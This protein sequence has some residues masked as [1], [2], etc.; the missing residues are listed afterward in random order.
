MA[1]DVNNVFVVLG[2]HRSG[3]SALTGCLNLLGMD[4]GEMIMP[5]NPDNIHGFFENIDIYAVHERLFSELGHSWDMVGELPKGWLSSDAA[6]GA[7]IELEQI[8]R[9]QFLGK[10]IWTIKDPRMCRL[11][12][13]WD[14]LF[15]KLEINPN[16]IL[17][18]RDP[19]EVA[20]SLHKRDGMDF[21]KAC[22]LWAVH[23]MEAIQSMV[24]GSH[25]IVTYDQLLSDPIS[26]LKNVS[27]HFKMD[28]LGEDPA[29][30]SKIFQFVQPRLKHN[31]TASAAEEDAFDFRPYTHVYRLLQE[32][33]LS[34]RDAAAGEL[35]PPAKDVT[36]THELEKFS[37]LPVTGIGTT[38]QKDVYFLKDVSI[39]K[40]LLSVIGA[41]ER[42]ERESQAAAKVQELF[43]THSGQAFRFQI[44]FPLDQT[45][46]SVHLEKASRNVY[47]VPGDWKELTFDIPSPRNLR[48]QHVRIDPINQCGTIAIAGIQLQD[49]ASG[50][51][52]WE[53]QDAQ[54]F[55]ELTYNN[56]LIVFSREKPLT[57]FSIGTDPQI[58]LPLLP[59]LPDTPVRLKIWIKVLR[60]LDALRANVQSLSQENQELTANT[61]KLAQSEQAATEQAAR[62]QA[63]EVELAGLREN[64]EAQKAARAAA[65]KLAQERKAQAEQANAAQA[66]KIQEAQTE[67]AALRENAEAQK[68]ARAA[69][70]KLAQDRKIQAEQANVAQAAKIQEAQAEQ[71]ALRKEVEAQK[72]ARAAAEKLAQDRKIQAEQANAAQAAKIQEAQAEQA[73]LRKEVEAQKAARAAVE[74]LAQERR[75]EVEQATNEK[76]A[77][78][79]EVETQKAARAAVE[80]LAQDRRVEVEQAANQLQEVQVE[81]THLQDE[82]ITLREEVE[83]QKA[84]RTAAEKLAQE[85]KTQVEQANAAQAAK[86]QEAQTELAALRKEAEAQKAARAAAEKLAQDRKTEIE[87]AALR[88]QGIQVELTRF[89]DD[90]AALRREVDMHKVLRAAAEKLA[91]DHKAQAEQAA[92]AQIR[93]LQEAQ[94]EIDQLR[95]EITTL[96]KNLKSRYGEVATLTTH[97]QTSE[98][99]KQELVSALENERSAATEAAQKVQAELVT[100]REEIQTQKTARAAAE[101]QAQDRKAEAEQNKQAQAELVKARNEVSKLSGKLD[102]RYREVAVLTTQLQS[103]DNDRS[104]LQQANESTKKIAHDE[105]D[106]LDVIIVGLVSMLKNTIETFKDRHFG[107]AKANEQLQKLIDDVKGLGLVDADWYLKTHQDVREAGMDPV[108][109]YILHG[110]LEN[111]GY[112]PK[113]L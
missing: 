29:V 60:T 73:A 101:K 96:T 18:V 47:L 55:A 61:A 67:L 53:A 22:L 69:V 85:R 102:D 99:E 63:A 19:V 38:K 78:R 68:A 34:T 3:T 70:E 65:E 83:A 56:Q 62:I 109:H 42:T 95:E 11:M 72:A 41:Y 108:R 10:R 21:N 100:L 90:Q 43:H 79:K 44:F 76:A 104:K 35:A 6:H 87:Q 59:Q 58:M 23:N 110:V 64:V 33:Q 8:L 107:K 40:D 74:K 17:M 93:R 46:G 49:A 45:N 9:T 84:A 37:F 88:L 66:A 32:K 48:K 14:E 80:K 50:E 82:L 54:Q 12:P 28:L 77:L 106:R 39:V 4:L 20:F 36:G 27:M 98:N 16:Y 97:L 57:C 94:S 75:V 89:Q 24:Q 1:Y 5:A 52:L 92:A 103:A 71:A 105:L 112:G 25:T 51:I 13:L 91:Q 86:I 113:K 30:Y 7:A 81:L 15:R 31:R 26:L 2:M 111:R